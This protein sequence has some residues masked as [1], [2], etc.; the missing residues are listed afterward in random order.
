MSKIK[1]YIIEKYGEQAFDYIDNL[2]A[3]EG[4]EL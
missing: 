2:G 4:Y 3:E 1:T